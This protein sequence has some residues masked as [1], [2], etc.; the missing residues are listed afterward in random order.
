ALPEAV[1]HEHADNRRDDDA[2]A[3]AGDRASGDDV[4]FLRRMDHSGL[5]YTAPVGRNGS[6]FAT[7]DPPPCRQAATATQVPTTAASA[8][9]S[10]QWNTSTPC[11]RDG[12][13]CQ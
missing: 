12:M 10:S 4:G 13:T 1:G 5:R 6:R 7:S 8:P 3:D 11:T 9:R 2:D